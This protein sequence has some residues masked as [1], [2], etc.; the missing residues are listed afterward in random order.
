MN[1][2]TTLKILQYNV[3]KSRD[4]VMATLL[5]DPR[6]MEYDILA[7]QEPWRN[8]FMST[9]HHP[10]KAQF[11]LC[12]PA[13]IE[14]GP[15]RVCFFV[16]KGLDNTMWQ[17]KSHTRDACSLQIQYPVDDQTRGCLH[18]HNI[19][20]SGQTTEDRESVL[21]LILTLLETHQ[22]DDRIV[23]G[24]FNLHHRSWGGERVIREDREAEELK[25]IMDQ[26]GLTNTLHEGS[27]TY[28][29]CN[30]QSTIDL[31]WITIGLLD[32]LVKSIVDRE[33]DHDSD[34]FPITTVLDMN[35]KHKD[36]KPK[37]NWK[38]LD[39]M[40]LCEALRQ[41]LPQLQRPRTKA[42]LDRCTS[43]LVEAIDEAVE[44]V[45]PETRYSTKSRESW[46]DECSRTLAESKRLRRAHCREH[47]EESW[48]AYRAA[49]YTKTRTI[50]KAL[51]T[52]HREKIAAASD[53]PGAL[54][55]LTKWARGTETLPPS[56]KPS[57][58]CPQTKR[59][60]ETEW[61]NIMPK[62]TCK[63]L[64]V[65]MD[66]RL[67]WKPHIEKIRQKVSKSINALACLGS[68]TW[69][70]SMSD[71]RKIYNGVVVPQMMYACS[72][73]SDS[74]SKGTPYTV[75]TMDALRSIQA[76]GARAICGA[77]KATSRA[78]L[79]IE[80]NL[81]PVAQQIEKNNA[82]TLSRVMSS[83]MI[84]EFDGSVDDRF[85]R[86]SRKTPYT[87]PMRSIHRQC[88]GSQPVELYPM[89]TIPPFVAPPWRM[90]PRI[91][92]EEDSCA[93]S[94]H[95]REIAKDRICIYT[96]GSSIGGHVGVA[97]VYLDAGQMRNTYM[98]TDSTSTVYA[99]EL[100]GS[101][102]R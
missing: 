10:A 83:S 98:G 84:S 9:T 96:D 69:G 91:H 72:V 77:F 100:Q 95:D 67:E 85:N 79:D 38:K 66:H 39:E 52:A 50:R 87:S 64:G 31:C 89:E 3:R 12:Y 44:K 35:I 97:A 46:T 19:Y 92:I 74:R 29:E 40:K 45:L 75:K 27:I 30:A 13:A 101:T 32:R 93:R 33:L 55:R 24:D 54:W 90:G 57:I 99:A 41:T 26:F 70:V 65:V 73:W 86:I 21:P 36:V 60:A 28:E 4:T 17:F 59:E 25:I 61:G 80:T 76:R 48:E 7:I 68:S 5:R 1:S 78:A 81:L 43:N 16:N 11:H 56:V 94:T 63:Y 34:H 51:R 22:L 88:E 53:S 62:T 14:G 23:L 6:V 42:A 102:L 71:M 8:P 49:R 20:N 15:A 47:T 82:H 37:R 2:K 58:Q 18:I